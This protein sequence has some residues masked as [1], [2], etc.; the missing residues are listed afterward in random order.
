MDIENS[1]ARLTAESLH[2]AGTDLCRFENTIP[3]PNQSD[4]DRQINGIRYL[5]LD[6]NHLPAPIRRKEEEFQRKAQK[7]LKELWNLYSEDKPQLEYERSEW[8]ARAYYATLTNLTD[9]PECVNY[10]PV[11]V[12]S[13]EPFTEANYPEVAEQRSETEQRLVA[14]Q[15]LEMRVTKEKLLDYQHR[16]RKLLC[17]LDPTEDKFFSDSLLKECLAKENLDTDTAINKVFGRKPYNPVRKHEK[18]VA[19]QMVWD[20]RREE[21]LLANLHGML[22]DDTWLNKGIEEESCKAF[23]YLAYTYLLKDNEPGRGRVYREFQTAFWS[24]LEEATHLGEEDNY[25]LDPRYG[26]ASWDGLKNLSEAFQTLDWDALYSDTSDGGT[27]AQEWFKEVGLPRL[28]DRTE[29]WWVAVPSVVKDEYDEED[30][31]KILAKARRTDYENLCLFRNRFRDDARSNEV[32]YRS[33]VKLFRA[34]LEQVLS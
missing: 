19:L 15:I 6:P 3:D 16:A 32:I 20:K 27:A 10:Y 12:N 13:D 4:E 22:W 9:D 5:Q 23:T 29:E 34:A 31:D 33:T 8:G 14:T 25:L 21:T 24:V 17:S 11:V 30:T 2:I 26:D 28:Y 1:L 7:L 18:R